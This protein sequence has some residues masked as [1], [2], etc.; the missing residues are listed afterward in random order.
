MAQVNFYVM[1]VA[2]MSKLT[3]DNINES[4]LIIYGSIDEQ[5]YNG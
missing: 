1:A 3:T 2:Q 5:T 4:F